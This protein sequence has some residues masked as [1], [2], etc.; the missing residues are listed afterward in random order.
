[1]K[2]RRPE[3]VDASRFMYSAIQID[4]FEFTTVSL[5]ARALVLFLSLIYSRNLQRTELFSG[6]G[7]KINWRFI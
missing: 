3:F 4:A 7:E 6:K 5:F 2:Y 1:M